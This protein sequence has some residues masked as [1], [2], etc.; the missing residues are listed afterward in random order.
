MPCQ[1]PLI[2]YKIYLDTY[3]IMGGR[4]RNI[5]IGEIVCKKGLLQG[6]YLSVILFILSLNP[7]SY[8]LNK[9][10]GYKMGPSEK[11]EKNLTHLP[12]V[13]DLKLYTSSMEK[14]Q[15]QLDII[16]TFSS[17]NVLHSR[18]LFKKSATGGLVHHYSPFDGNY[19]LDQFDGNYMFFKLMGK[20]GGYQSIFPYIGANKHHRQR[21]F[22][23]R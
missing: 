17:S 19:T 16:T 5:Q 2:P 11:R 18:A 22:V 9:S 15:Y 21:K 13:N 4:N 1:G 10:E 8:L 14:E 7:G 3:E 20:D 12:F 6:D 23:R